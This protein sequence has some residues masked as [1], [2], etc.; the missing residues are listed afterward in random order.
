MKLSNKEGLDSKVRAV[1]WFVS[2]FIF[3]KIMIEGK[4]D[5]FLFIIEV[6]SAL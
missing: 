6:Y 2:S 5:V 1:H 4:L 3:P